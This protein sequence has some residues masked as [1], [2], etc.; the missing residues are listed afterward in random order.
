VCIRIA[1]LLSMIP[2]AVVA[3]SDKPNFSGTWRLE[4]PNPDSATVLIINQDENEL[5]ISTGPQQKET[6]AVECSTTGRECDATVH[7]ERVKVSYYYNGPMLVEMVFEGKNNERVTKTRRT[8][9]ED[10]RNMKVEVIPMVP[11]GKE[12]YKLVFVRDEEVA[13]APA[14]APDKR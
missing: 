5:R 14:T 7:G 2:S 4:V 13:A 6:T 1:L 12:P 9:S 10:G 3:G 11:S 8:L